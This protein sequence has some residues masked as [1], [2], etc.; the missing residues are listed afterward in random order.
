M[1]NAMVIVALSLIGATLGSF[2]GA[3]VWRLRAKQLVEDSAAGESVDQAELRRLKPLLKPVATDRSECIHCHHTLAWYDLL[4]IVSWLTLRGK[5]RYCKRPIGKMEI[6]LEIGLAAIFAVSYIA[7]PCP[8]TNMV[9]IVPFAVWLLACVLMALLFAYDARWSLLPF[10]V[11]IALIGV[12]VVFISVS[13]ALGLHADV[14]L[15]SPL[16]ALGIMGGLYFIFSVAGW[17][18][19]GDSILGVGLALLLGRWELAFLAVFLANLLG[20]IML[21]PLALTKRLHRKQHIPFGPFLIVGTIVS[22]LWGWQL[23]TMG[24]QASNTI[25]TKLML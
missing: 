20:S 2:V 15:W 7:W 8:F 10:G 17:S 4:P 22:F 21:I 3:Q 1:E 18:G 23:V 9:A 5:C 12:G 16:L 6:F 19:L 14:P 24:M 13:F 25:I 11:N